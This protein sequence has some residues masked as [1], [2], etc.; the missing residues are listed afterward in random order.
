MDFSAPHVDFVLIC[1]AVSAVL[2]LGMTTMI[3]MRS[4]HADSQLMKLEAE[5]AKRR[6]AKAALKQ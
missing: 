3:V 4:R 5:R 1:Y 2:L 6:A